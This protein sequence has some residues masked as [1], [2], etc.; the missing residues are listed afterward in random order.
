MK[1]NDRQVCGLKPKDKPFKVSD[2]FGLYLEVLP[3]GSKSWRMK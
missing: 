2:G 3:S 1:L